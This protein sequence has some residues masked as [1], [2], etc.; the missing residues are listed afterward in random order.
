LYLWAAGVQLALDLF[1]D[2]G[3]DDR[4]NGNLNDFAFRFPPSGPRGDL[5]EPPSADIHRIGQNLVDRPDPKT[6]ASARE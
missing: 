5:I 6:L 1:E 4:W 3:I 2:V